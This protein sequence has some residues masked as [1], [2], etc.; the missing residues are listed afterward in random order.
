M[1][2]R[3]EVIK[4]ESIVGR[5][6]LGGIMLGKVLEYLDPCKTSYAMYFGTNLA[7]IGM[8][9]FLTSKLVEKIKRKIL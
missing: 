9:F 2:R 7:T 3:V 6:F 1:S 8:C 5:L 4:R